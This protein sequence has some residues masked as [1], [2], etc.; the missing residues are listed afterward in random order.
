[1]AELDWK[2]AELGHDFSPVRLYLLVF[3]ALF[4]SVAPL[5]LRE[6]KLVDKEIRFSIENL[7]MKF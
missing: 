7:K 1:M 6:L 3:Y 4:D 2:F 5:G